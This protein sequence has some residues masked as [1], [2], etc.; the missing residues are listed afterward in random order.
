LSAAIALG[1]LAAATSIGGCVV[2]ND[3]P[4]SQP[5]LSTGDPSPRANQVNAVGDPMSYSPNFSNV[6]ISGGGINT[7]RT[8]SM[9]RDLDDTLNP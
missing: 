6:D 3:D 4:A 7:L 5:S 2:Q 9:E 8:K 1:A